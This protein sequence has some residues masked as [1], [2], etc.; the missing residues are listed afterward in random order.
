VSDEPIF[1]IFERNSGDMDGLTIWNKC[2]YVC[3][4][5]GYYYTK[6]NQEQI[7]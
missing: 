6:V 3:F 1:R 7:R 2:S 5:L 4:T